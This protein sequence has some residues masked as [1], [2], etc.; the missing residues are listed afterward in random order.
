MLR[1]GSWSRPAGVS[2]VRVD[3]GVPGSRPQ[4]VGEIWRAKRGVESLFGGS[5]RA[6]RNV[7]V[8]P[9]ASSHPQ[10]RSRA[11][12]VTAKAMSDGPWSGVRSSG[13]SGV[14]G[15]ERAHGLDRNRRDPSAWPCRAKTGRISRW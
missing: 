14:G 13:L 11:A 5:K 10:R 3:T 15:A 6:V 8:N 1:P 12:H 7:E 2:P 4:F 9:A